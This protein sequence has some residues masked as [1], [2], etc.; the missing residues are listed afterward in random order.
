M[1]DNQ[2][3]Q[4]EIAELEQAIKEIK[5]TDDKLGLNLAEEDLRYAESLLAS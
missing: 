1:V 2:S 5:L 4:T 3:I